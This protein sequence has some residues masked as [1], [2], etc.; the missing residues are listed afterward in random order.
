MTNFGK[1][2]S[3]LHTVCYQS[4]C[5][6]NTSTKEGNMAR[7]TASCHLVKGRYAKTDEASYLVEL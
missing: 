2:G 7:L 5:A 6:E 3:V 1:K 4:R